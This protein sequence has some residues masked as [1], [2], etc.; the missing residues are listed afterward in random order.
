MSSS[1]VPLKTRRVGQ[2]C[3]LNLSRAQTSSCWCGV[4]VRREGA[5]SGVVL[6]TSPWFKITRSVAKSR[7]VAEQCDVNIHSLRRTRSSGSALNK[8]NVPAKF[9]DRIVMIHQTFGSTYLA[10]TY[11]LCTRRVFGGIRHR[12]LVFRSGVRC[13]SHKATHGPVHF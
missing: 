13:S 6:V 2:R 9:Q 5:S 8:R 1:P 3:T 10:S 7:R 12:N 4:V 11:S